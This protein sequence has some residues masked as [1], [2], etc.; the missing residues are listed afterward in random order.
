MYS[1]YQ[2]VLSV[3]RKNWDPFVLGPLLAMDKIPRSIITENKATTVGK[4]LHTNSDFNIYFGVAIYHKM[5]MK[6]NCNVLLAY[7]DVQA[8]AMIKAA[9]LYQNQNYLVHKLFCKFFQHK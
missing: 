1:I 6:S 4:R 3:H 2:S 9:S 5:G 7:F 8:T